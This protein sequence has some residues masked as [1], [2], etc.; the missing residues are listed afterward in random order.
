MAT[1]NITIE[2]PR[3]SVDSLALV[4]GVANAGGGRIIITTDTKDRSS[5]FRR[6]RK[7]FEQVPAAIQ[8]DMGLVCTTAP[9]MQEGYLCL[10]IDIP[11][12]PE[13][14]ASEGVYWL[15]TPEGNEPRTRGD[16]LRARHESEATAWEMR[17]LPFVKHEDVH[18][19]S[20]L[21]F[22]ALPLPNFATSDEGVRDT[23]ASRLE[24]IG[25]TR[26]HS[27]ELTNAGA[28]MLAAHPPRFVPGASVRLMTF[29]DPLFPAGSRDELAGPLGQLLEDTVRLIF[30]RYQSDSSPFAA[31]SRTIIPLPPE[32]A[33]R[34]A[35]A[36]AL[37]HKDYESGVP[38]RVSLHPDRLVISNVGGL[39][40]GWDIERLLGEH[41]PRP[42]NP[43]IAATAHLL[44]LAPGWGSGISQMISACHQAGFAAPSFQIDPDEV[45][46]SFP[47]EPVELED[48]SSS[49]SL[50]GVSEEH[51]DKNSANTGRPLDHIAGGPLQNRFVDHSIAAANRLD[52]TNTDEYVLRVLA[53][54]GRATAV[55][56]A[57][58]LGVSERT[59]R[60]SFKKLRELGFI[61]RIGLDKAGYWNL[62]E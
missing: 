31:H 60:R 15:Y 27:R 32:A 26:P 11:E 17:P 5:G 53:T 16:I 62:L 2:Q 55:R 38:V 28:V 21:A 45:Q 59:V 1:G 12:A 48:Q 43:T 44:Q 47:F 52:M 18:S 36:N 7:P 6:M 29:G 8:R 20:V 41:S 13:P 23:L 50:V 51:A 24:H 46:V 57:E 14:V 34:E 58:V 35:L 10:E 4:C 19:D 49:M 22:G 40:E 3:W 54:N 42:R 33:I 25:L 61:E 30:G 9:V 39:P 37:V 56:I